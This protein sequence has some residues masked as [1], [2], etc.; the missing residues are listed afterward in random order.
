MPFNIIGVYML[1][2]ADDTFYDQLAEFLKECSHNKN[3]FLLVI[4]M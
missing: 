3:Y 1:P 2:S 4:L